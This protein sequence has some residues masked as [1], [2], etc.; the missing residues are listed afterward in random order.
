MIIS[1][2]FHSV[3][4]EGSLTGQPSVFIRTAGCNLRCNWCDTDYASWNPEGEEMT[5]EQV[6]NKVKSYNCS[7]VVLTGGEPMIAKDIHQLAE[8]LYKNNLHITIETAGTVAPDNIRCHLASI[9]PKTSNSTPDNRLPESWWKRHERDR[10]QPDILNQWLG[11]YPYQFKFVVSTPDD[12]TEIQQLV[13]TVGS[14]I[15][16]DKIFLMPEGVT[17]EQ[18]DSKTDFLLDICRKYG[19]RYC[20]RLHIRLFGNKKGT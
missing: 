4:G 1:E 6:V 3:Q 12:I 15:P 17:V 8:K 14:T 20:D 5:V 18:L 7:Y 13:H 9:S 19:Y 10:F 16:P 11:R 2:I